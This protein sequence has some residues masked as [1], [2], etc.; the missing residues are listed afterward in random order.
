MPRFQRAWQ[1]PDGLQR[2]TVHGMSAKPAFDRPHRDPRGAAPAF[3]VGGKREPERTRSGMPRL[4][5]AIRAP[6]RSRSR[7]LNDRLSISGGFDLPGKLP[8]DR[9]RHLPPR[10]APIRRSRPPRS[11]D[12][13][14]LA[15]G[16]QPSAHESPRDY[17]D[18]QSNDRS[19]IGRDRRRAGPVWPDDISVRDRHGLL[20]RPTGRAEFRSTCNARA[21]QELLPLNDFRASLLTVRFTH[22]AFEEAR[23]NTE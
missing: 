9:K 11:R 18:R 5:S 1:L 7:T 12:R 15:G 21:V 23:S 3:T 13:S 8:G 20:R 17:R 10:H 14:R 16:D 22:A 6:R 4:L 19:A 2:F